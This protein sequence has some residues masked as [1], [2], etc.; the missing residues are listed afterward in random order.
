MTR[1]VALPLAGAALL[2]A[3]SV[4]RLPWSAWPFGFPAT[5]LQHSAAQAILPDC[6]LLIEASRLLPEDASV[7]VRREPRNPWAET[8][9]HRLAVALLPGRRVLPAAIWGSPAPPDLELRA[10]YVVVLGARPEPPP[11]ELLL[12]TP[13]GTI[14]RRPAN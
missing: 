14:W 10:R 2:A 1:R 6:R 7:L 13:D 8:L 12:T 9:F 5:P 4:A 11:G 3:L